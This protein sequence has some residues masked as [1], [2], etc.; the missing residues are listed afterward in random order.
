MMKIENFYPIT[1]LFLFAVN[2][3]NEDMKASNEKS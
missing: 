2:E 1:T 3:L